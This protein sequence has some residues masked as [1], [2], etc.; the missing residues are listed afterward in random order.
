MAK[1]GEFTAV[2]LVGGKGTRLGLGKKPKPL[3]DI[4]GVPLLERMIFNFKSQGIKNFIMLC[5]FGSDQIAQHLN[6]QKFSGLNIEIIIEKT[7]LGTA[8]SFSLIE[9]LVTN[10]FIVVYGDLL[11]EVDLERFINFGIKKNCL[12]LLYAHPNDHPEDSDLI[13]VDLENKVLDFISKPHS[14]P[15][16]GNLSNAAFYL[17]DKS[18][19]KYLPN[20]VEGV[21]DWGKD[22]FPKMV[23]SNENMFVYRGTEYLKDIGTPQRIIRGNNDFK[24][25]KVSQKSYKQKQKAIFFDR[26]GIINE[27]VDGVYNKSMFKLRSEAAKMIK[28][29]NK[30]NYLA[31]CVTNQPGIAKGFMTIEDLIKIHYKMEWLLAESDGSYLDDI[32]FCPHHPEKGFDGEIKEYKI[33]CECR[34]PKPGMILEA[35]K[36]HNIDLKKSY[37]IGDHKRDIDAANSVN[38]KSFLLTKELCMKNNKVKSIC[39]ALD[40]IL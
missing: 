30:S 29:V 31:I 10:K 35:A 4:E 39:E 26:D 17:F 9:N 24:K 19:Y 27:E 6:Q 8:G 33:D 18:I 36:K 7:P 25:G 28:R 21:I 34:K 13:K 2:F 22:I 11:F 14:N 20:K 15:D 40:Q 16:C 37:L 38:V 3:V 32:L 5:G 23:A 12:A 1:I